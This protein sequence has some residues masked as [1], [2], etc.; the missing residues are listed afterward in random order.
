MLILHLRVTL[1]RIA[2]L[3]RRIALLR[4]VTALGLIPLLGI[5][6]ASLIVI[7]GRHVGDSDTQATK[8]LTS[9]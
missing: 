4:W 2:L 6:R 3:R 8:L 9:N 5:L 1:R 7:L